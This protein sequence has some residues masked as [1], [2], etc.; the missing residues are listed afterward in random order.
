ML[1]PKR[2]HENIEVQRRADRGTRRTPRSRAKG[3]CHLFNTSTP[4][5]AFKGAMRFFISCSSFRITESSAHYLLWAQI[6]P[7][8]GMELNHRSDGLQPNH[9]AN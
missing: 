1:R 6:K 5:A 3:A 8:V 9:F 4:P 2:A 7:I